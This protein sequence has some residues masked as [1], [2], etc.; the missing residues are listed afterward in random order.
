MVKVYPRVGGGTL[1]R[2]STLQTDNGLSPRVR[3]TRM[4][5]PMCPRPTGLSPACAGNRQPSIDHPLS[6][7]SIPACAGEPKE[8][9]TRTSYQRVYPR[10]CGGTPI[11]SLDEWVALGLSPRGRGNHYH[12]PRMVRPSRSIPA[13]AGEP[14]KFYIYIGCL[15]VYPRVCGEPSARRTSAP[16]LSVYPRVCGEPAPKRSSHTPSA[17]YPRVCGGTPRAPRPSL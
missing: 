5:C 17:V 8:R 13:C 9:L 16:L 6:Y 14:S 4:M 12:R 3:G 11:R 2:L 7:R 15:G 1:H 10:V